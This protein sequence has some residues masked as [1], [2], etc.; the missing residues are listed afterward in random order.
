MTNKKVR[1][2]NT[3]AISELREK[4]ATIEERVFE[5]GRIVEILAAAHGIDIE[6]LR[7]EDNN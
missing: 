7:E 1:I 5:I 6:R 3:K 2:S 4:I